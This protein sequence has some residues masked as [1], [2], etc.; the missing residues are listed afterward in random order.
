[1]R[2]TWAWSD[3]AL[4]A[5]ASCPE[6]FR[7]MVIQK[8]KE[9]S[10]PAQL[11]G[12]Y[13]HDVMEK[14]AKKEVESIFDGILNTILLFIK[15]DDKI[16]NTGF[17]LAEDYIRLMNEFTS[18]KITKF[19]GTPYT[20]PQMTNYWKD[21]SADLRLELRQEKFFALEPFK[22]DRL[23]SLISDED[24]WNIFIDLLMME[25]KAV[26][27]EPDLESALE[28]IAEGWI[29]DYGLHLPGIPRKFVGK[30]DLTLK[31]AENHWEVYDY[32]TGHKNADLNQKAI[33]SFQLTA[34]AKHIKDK[35]GTW[36]KKASLVFLEVGESADLVLTPNEWQE[37]WAYL[38]E[39]IQRAERAASAIV[40]D[41]YVPICLSGYPA[42]CKNCGYREECSIKYSVAI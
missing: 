3:T 30:L 24:L 40:N 31:F 11:K 26:K 42:G 33:E 13:F 41:Q 5:I 37:R 21:K 8:Q 20:N 38:L 2:S 19:D 12:I 25:A 27:V 34:I 28:I 39:I 7:R 35:Y 18:G 1:M 32:K 29:G 10:N 17:A 15:D 4:R 9:P 36:P 23:L 16:L 6:K 14:H 22:R